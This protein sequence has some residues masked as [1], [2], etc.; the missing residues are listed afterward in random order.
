VQRAGGGG[1]GEEQRQKVLQKLYTPLIAL[2]HRH[3]AFSTLFQIC[4]DLDDHKL[5]R[6][7]MVRMLFTD[8]SSLFFSNCEIQFL[9]SPQCL[10]VNIFLVVLQPNR[11]LRL[12]G[13]VRTLQH[14]D[15][16]G[17]FYISCNI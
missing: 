3:A 10:M 13:F 5:L 8:L 15:D 7:L 2:G 17:S 9:V 6:R 1:K 16:S 12:A 14:S 11:C 4:M